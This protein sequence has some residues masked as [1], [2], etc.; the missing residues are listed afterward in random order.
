MLQVLLGEEASLVKLFS[1][2]FIDSDLHHLYTVPST[3][4]CLHT[5]FTFTQQYEVQWRILS[6]SSKYSSHAHAS[7]SSL[8]TLSRHRD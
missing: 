5:Y 8:L 7:L 3:Q 6:Y 2:A 4:F 1:A